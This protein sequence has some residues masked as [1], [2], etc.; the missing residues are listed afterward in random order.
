MPRKPRDRTNRLHRAGERA[1]FFVSTARRESVQFAIHRIPK[2][3]PW[4]LAHAP[5]ARTARRRRS[6][7]R[8][9]RRAIRR[10]LDAIELV[11]AAPRGRG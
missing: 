6:C 3:R 8:L 1:A 4:V 7:E 11:A 5:T 10:D 2:A 9:F